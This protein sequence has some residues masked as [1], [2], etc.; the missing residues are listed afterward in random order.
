MIE[1]PHIFADIFAQLSP[2]ERGDMRVLLTSP[3]YVKACRIIATQKPKSVGQGLHGIGVNEHTAIKSA[4]KLS[5]IRGWE[6]YEQALWLLLKEPDQIRQEVPA[7]YPDS[8]RMDFGPDVPYKKFT[9][10]KRAK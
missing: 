8:S 2:D 7:N 6:L 4:I 10:S 9:A 5:E 1:Q 3:L